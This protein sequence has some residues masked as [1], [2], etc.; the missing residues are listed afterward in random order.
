MFMNGMDGVTLLRLKK[1]GTAEKMYA[2]TPDMASE[3]M[4]TPKDQETDGDMY[5]LMDD[6]DRSFREIVNVLLM[7]LVKGD[8]IQTIMHLTA[9]MNPELTEPMDTPEDLF[10]WFF[11]KGE[12]DDEEA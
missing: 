12:G 6:V 9:I 11:E 7:S 5:L 4:G 3:L 1:D 2:A 10:N 8:I